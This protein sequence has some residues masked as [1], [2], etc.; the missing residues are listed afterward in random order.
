MDE[1][2]RGRLAKAV[3][4]RMYA[5]DAAARA[6]GIAILEVGPGRARAR[7]T[8][9]PDMLNSHRICHGGVLFTLADT[10][11][12]YACN[13]ANKATLASTCTITYAS[14]AQAGEELTADARE[15]LRQGRSG[16]Y[17]VA[18]TA[19]DGRVVALFR[20]QSREVR[21]ESVPGLGPA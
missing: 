21:G 9:R 12:A 19:A 1:D 10:A 4:E 16:V 17:D 13:G 20:G 11:F 14:P 5:Q 2:G 6:Q 15:V 7:M 8:V 18:V 3:A